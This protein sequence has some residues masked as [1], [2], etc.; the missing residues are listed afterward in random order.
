M[1]CRI[2]SRQCISAT[3]SH[4]YEPYSFKTCG[5][6]EKYPV[7]TV[8]SIQLACSRESGDVPPPM[9]DMLKMIWWGV[10]TLFRSRVSLEAEILTLRHQ[11]DVLRRKSPKRLAFSNVDRLIF[12]TSI[13][14]CRAL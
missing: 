10:I 13:G 7:T 6:L 8:N 11:L 3:A 1:S 4:Y 2:R 14:L 5:R 9:G 12:T